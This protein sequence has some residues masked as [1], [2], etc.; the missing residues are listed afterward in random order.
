[1]K[2]E[3]SVLV[4]EDGRP[5]ITPEKKL[6]VAIDEGNINFETL[7]RNDIPDWTIKTCPSVED[8]FRAVASGE[9][10]GVLACNFRMSDY[11][12]FR[13][14]YKL[15]ALPT[16]E[17]MELS[18]AVNEDNPELYSILNKIANLTSG[19]DMEY[20]LI[21]YMYT[22]QKVSLQ[23][24]L[25]DNWIG[26]LL[27]ITAVFSALRLRKPGRLQQV[28]SRTVPESDSSGGF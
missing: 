24:Y 27:F 13:T 7:I 26:V 20:A 1:M 8:C 17:T 15:V 2:T 4:K 3:M 10:D 25:K 16:G 6:T 23:D 9:A 19:E 22:N 11:E 18:F 12:P 5:E 21:S 28:F 14:K